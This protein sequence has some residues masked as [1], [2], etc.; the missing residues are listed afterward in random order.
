VWRWTCAFLDG[1][2]VAQAQQPLDGEASVAEVGVVE[3]LRRAAVDEPAIKLH[4]LGDLVVPLLPANLAALLLAVGDD[5]E[6]V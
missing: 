5:S 1:H 4:D 2:L 6:T 3:A